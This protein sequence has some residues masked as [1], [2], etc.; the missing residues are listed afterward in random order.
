MRSYGYTARN[1]KTTKPYNHKNIMKKNLY[2]AMLMALPT[3]AQQTEQV[4]TFEDLPLE[5]ESFWNGSDGTGSFTS[6]MFRFENGYVDYG[7]YGYAYGFYYS[8][9]TA[10]NFSEYTTDQ[11]NSCVGHGAEDSENY[12]VYNVNIYNPKGVQVLAE[13]GAVVGGCYITNAAS[14]YQSMLNGDEY[15]KKFGDGDWFKLTITGLNAEGTPTGSVDFY[16]A[17]FRE[18]G[19]AYIVSDWQWVDLSGLGKVARLSFDM[20]SSDSGQWGMNTPAYFCLDNLGA[21]KPED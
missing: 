5:K 4:A 15:A 8:N 2:L 6:G 12:A 17:D 21:S 19:N 11:Y 3:M 7:A 14:A 20:S 16:L 13:G 18:A 1:R 10:T 9:M